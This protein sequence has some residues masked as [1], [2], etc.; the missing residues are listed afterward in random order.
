MWK[1]DCMAASLCPPIVQS[2]ASYN[3]ISVRS[4]KDWDEY[5][6]KCLGK[7]TSAPPS[8]IVIEDIIESPMDPR[9]SDSGKGQAL[10]TIE[11][12]APL[13][14]ALLAIIGPTSSPIQEGTAIVPDIQVFDPLILPK[15]ALGISG[16][17]DSKALEAILPT[18]MVINLKTF[19]IAPNLQNQ[20]GIIIHMPKPFPYEDNHRVRWKYDVSLISIQTRK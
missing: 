5:L 7:A 17:S 11:G 6:L 1:G 18:S 9:S 15:P 12:F 20:E 19:S 10:P 4:R 8:S 3:S 2:G 16:V 13:V 14:L